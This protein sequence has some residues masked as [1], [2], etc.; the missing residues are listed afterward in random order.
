LLP[1][2]S[3][4]SI[5]ANTRIFSFFTSKFSTRSSAQAIAVPP[6]AIRSSII[7]ILSLTDI[8]VFFE[9]LLKYYHTQDQNFFDVFH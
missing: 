2:R 5:T 6:V 1:P 9:F 3:G 4:K 8:D 7:T